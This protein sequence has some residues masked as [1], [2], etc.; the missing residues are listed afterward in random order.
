MLIYYVLISP[1]AIQP[2]PAPIAIK[3]EPAPIAIKPGLAPI[4]IK[5]EPAPIAVKPEPAGEEKLTSIQR[6]EFQFADMADK[7]KNALI[8]NKVNIVVLIQKLCSISVIKNKNVPLFDK[9]LFEEVKSIDD[10]WNKLRGFWTI[11]DYDLLECIVEVSDCAEAQQIFRDFVSKIDPSI[12]KDADLV[13][14]CKVEH[15]EGLLMPVLRIKVNAEE[16]TSEV[17]KSVEN[18]VSKAYELDKYKFCFKGIKEGCIELVYCISK[19]LKLY[20]SNFKI[21]G[22]NMA[23]FLAHDVISL[24]ID[25]EFELKVPPKIDDIMVS[26]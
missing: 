13:L 12:I 6:L 5:P 8:K 7:I 20:L 1:I 22:R 16:C 14:H 24:H 18:I 4:A 26:S 19:P 15:W 17:K 3:P 23:E 10:F 21:I 9:D 25:N 2:G 11:F